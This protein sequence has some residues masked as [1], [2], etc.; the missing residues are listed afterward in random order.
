M[1]VDHVTQIEVIR[2]T[3]VDEFHSGGDLALFIDHRAHQRTGAQVDLRPAGVDAKGQLD[4]VAH[5]AE[6]YPRQQTGA[7]LTQIDHPGRVLCIGGNHGAYQLHRYSGRTAD[8]HGLDFIRPGQVKIGEG[9][10]IG[11]KN[12]GAVTHRVP[13]DESAYQQALAF[14]DEDQPAV[15]QGR[16]HQYADRT[17]IADKPDR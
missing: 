13:P 11:L 8:A 17:V 16:G 7:A 5:R 4:L 2:F 6:W 12:P 9:R 15:G 14:L 3:Q 10:E 1:L